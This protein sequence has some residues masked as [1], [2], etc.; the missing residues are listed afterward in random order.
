MLAS[1]L[2]SILGIGIS[3]D[4]MTITNTEIPPTH[5]DGKLLRLDLTKNHDLQN[6]EK[7]IYDAIVKNKNA[8]AFF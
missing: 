1:L 5:A 6:N 2:S 3:A 8:S 4:N 7:E